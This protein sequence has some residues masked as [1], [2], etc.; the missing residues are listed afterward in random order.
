MECAGLL[1]NKNESEFI[2]QSSGA[3]L[4]SSIRSKTNNNTYIWDALH[5]DTKEKI[6]N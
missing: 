4:V 1:V 6:K 3:L 5:S 2:R